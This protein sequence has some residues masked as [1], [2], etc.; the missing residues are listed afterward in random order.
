[1]V[2]RKFASKAV[3]K[4]LEDKLSEIPF[5]VGRLVNA[6]SFSR[7]YTTAS[8]GTRKRHTR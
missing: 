8:Y 4:V 5:I 3:A 7:P 1:M 2:I 6:I